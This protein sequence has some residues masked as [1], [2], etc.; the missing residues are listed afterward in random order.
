MKVLVITPRYGRDYKSKAKA[1]EAWEM[2]KDFT[3]GLTGV[4]VSIGDMGFIRGNGYTHVR[5]R[6][7][8][9]ADFAERA[10]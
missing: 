1:F 9:C 4:A 6:F 10:L 8:N 2:G 3:H 7:N 5:I